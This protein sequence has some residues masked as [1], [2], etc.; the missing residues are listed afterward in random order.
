MI[1][2]EEKSVN[3]KTE[4]Y[5]CGDNC[6]T[7]DIRIDDKFFCC[8]GCK[9]VYE[10]LNANNLCNYYDIEAKP[11]ISRKADI[12]RNYDFLDDNDFKK[13]LIDFSDGQ[14][15]TVTFYI[16]GIHCSSC[17]WVL[18]SLNRLNAGIKFSQ[19]DFLKKNVAIRFSEKETSIKEIVTLL[20]SI[21]YEPSLN[22][23]DKPLDDSGAA[24]KK[25]Y[26]K[27][28]IAGFCF[29]NIMLLSFPEY[30]SISDVD[31]DNIKYI[32]G[33]LN[34]LLSLPV[35]FYSSSIYFISAWKGLRNKIFNI[36]V[37]VS[38]GIFVLFTRS[39]IEILFQSGAGYFDSLSGLVFFLLLGR[40][41]QNKTYETLNFERNYKSYFPVAVTIRKNGIETT[42]PLDKVETG[43]R[44][45][46]KNGELIPGDSVLI[47]GVANIDYSFVTGESAL[48]PKKIGDVIYAGGRQAGGVIEVET[49][50]K[51]SQS[52][53]T[54]L[55]N[56]KA[57]AKKY[58]SPIDSLVDR[59][60]KH[61][62]FAILLIGFVAGVIWLPD[63][64]TAMN[65][66]TAVLIV[67]CPCALALSTPFT[68]GNS[69][70]IMGRN[71]L[72]IKNT[73][74]IEKLSG[75][76]SIVFDKTGTITESGSDVFDF[77]GSELM[78]DDLMLI[79]SL[80]RNSTHPL[81]QKIFASISESQI[82]DTLN[83][84]EIPGRGIEGTINGKSVK[85][86]SSDF[87]GLAENENHTN[88]TSS[89]VFVNID[90]EVRGYF[91]MGNKYREGLKN[92]V[93]SLSK[94]YELTMLSGDNESEKSRLENLFPQNAN[95]L[96]KQSPF[97]K[98]IFIQSLQAKGKNIL[99]L[100]DGLNDAGA[101]KQS[102][103][104]ISVTENI[105]MFSPASDGILEAQQFNKL[106]DFIKFSKD[107][108]NI[109]IVSFL[110]SFIYNLVGLGFAVNGSLSPIIA[111][112]LMP[113]SSISIVIFTTLSTNFLARRRGL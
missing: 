76:D 14:T 93:S 91:T 72:Y 33:Y 97:D 88:D 102:D 80:V 113:I 85:A 90:G 98:L 81:S 8:N 3:V 61:F 68:L 75:V 77:I 105:N 100:G 45:I 26:Y 28:G 9:T 38:L 13:S 54:Q 24:N 50:K 1:T 67:A 37:P 20:D 23:E 79:K 27:I 4:C 29:G 43:N 104:G 35:M 10:I 111:A 39:A 94:D 74:V 17:I 78:H 58:D 6:P 86:G 65:A 53:L 71:N 44:I 110:I 55:W 34:L 106:K 46:I 62:T 12:K 21:G 60:S 99:M 51:V 84:S 22:A 87:V 18:E 31:N 64:S 92:I 95:L 63:L 49:I 66:F 101:L 103:V 69:L 25:L 7:E 32:F 96:F 19:A 11:G 2:T 57:F 30:L 48:I 40:L 70:R 89:K 56:S 112:I 83:Y 36:D 108:K 109:I 5:H 15:T 16:P 41:F 52:Y 47:K 73:S 42:I 82:F 59:I 107:S